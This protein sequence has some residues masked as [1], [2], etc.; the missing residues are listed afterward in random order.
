[1]PL[2]LVILILIAERY[3]MIVVMMQDLFTC[4]PKYPLYWRLKSHACILNKIDPLVCLSKVGHHYCQYCELG[5]KKNAI[6]M[7]N[8]IDC[9][10]FMNFCIRKLP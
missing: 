7:F 4:A 2:L 3:M 6:S 5:E 1:M 10:I 8:S 9:D